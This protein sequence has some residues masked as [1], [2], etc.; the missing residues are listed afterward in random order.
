MKKVLVVDQHQPFREFLRKILLTHYDVI[1]ASEAREALHLISRQNPDLLILDSE[2]KEVCIRM[3]RH[4]AMRLVPVL[5][6]SGVDNDEV[7]FK[8]ASARRVDC[9]DSGA[10]DVL[11][12]T[13]SIPEFLAR[14]RAILRIYSLKSAE[15]GPVSLGNLEIH[16]S[17]LMVSI[18]GRPLDLTPT[19]FD[20]VRYF[21]ERPGRAVPRKQLL[22]DL[23]P[24][25]VV[26]RRTIDTHI[27][28]LRKKL[29]G[30][31]YR[32][33]TVYGSGYRL[34]SRSEEACPA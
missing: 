12:K 25:A 20:L 23:W 28:N 10:D 14:I 21:V 31:D 30:F 5:M 17:S 15:A 33:E 16:P 9:L 29:V 18:N 11:D 19:E 34:S 1:E 2:Q 27:A 22:G 4:P 3:R 7:N 32:F 26:T 6:I 13:F 8:E 24:D